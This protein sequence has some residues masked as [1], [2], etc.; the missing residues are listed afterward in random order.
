M[1]Y[2]P[3]KRWLWVFEEVS[4]IGISNRMLSDKMTL[5]Q[6]RLLTFAD[7]AEPKSIDELRIDFA[8]N[9]MGAEKAPGS[10]EHGVKWLADLEKIVIDPTS[11]PLAA[12]EFVNYSLEMNRDG[13]VISR[14]PDKN[15]HSIDAVRYGLYDII[16]SKPKRRSFDVD[17][18]PI[19]NRW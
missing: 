17:V 14:Y 19:V 8:L 10:V 7:K 5:D 9:I 1:Y 18:M 6:K 15:N 13:Q 3:R 2:D 12:M 4:G 16:K 11:C